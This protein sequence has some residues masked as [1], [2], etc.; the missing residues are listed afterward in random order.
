MLAHRMP[1]PKPDGLVTATG[2]PDVSK[3]KAAEDAVALI[4]NSVQSDTIK[5]IA[6]CSQ[7][8]MSNAVAQPLIEGPMI[9]DVP[10]VNERQ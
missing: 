4:N 1:L 5:I 3:V 9:T 8:T 10:P 2:S 7:L 6:A